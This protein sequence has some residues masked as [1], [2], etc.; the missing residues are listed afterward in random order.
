MN[1]SLY[2]NNF[3]NCLEL[4][5]SA[6]LLKKNIDPCSIWNQSGL[7]YKELEEEWILTPYYWRIEPYL[8]SNGIDYSERHY[9]DETKL[10]TDVKEMMNL[11]I[12]IGLMLDVHELPYSMYFQ[13]YHDIHAIEMVKFDND[14]FE[15]YDHYYHYHGTIDLYQL[16]KAIQSYRDFF[17]KDM[18]HFFYIDAQNKKLI[19]PEEIIMNNF[20]VMS[21]KA[22]KDLAEKASGGYVG[23]SAAPHIKNMVLQ[24]LEFNHSNPDAE[25][26]INDMFKDLK[27]LSF[28][29]QNY[30]DFLNH[31]AKF[32]FA[33]AVQ[34]ASQSWAVTANMVLLASV[35]GDYKG[36]M[37]RITKRL[38]RSFEHELIVHEIVE[39]FLKKKAFI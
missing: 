22:L 24:I 30:Y 16:L 28:S 7:F 37:P 20:S 39:S 13:E 29:R 10:M 5:I 3:Q 25:Y 15:I 38:D 6:M 4:V 17:E 33:S 18:I 34:E 32:E 9:T 23:L 8:K 35:S 12:S 21:G 2:K 11:G 19:T 31:T 36:M 1:D 27:E 14:V 26:L